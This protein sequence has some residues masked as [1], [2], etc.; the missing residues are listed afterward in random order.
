MAGCFDG[1]ANVLNSP[2]NAFWRIEAEESFDFAGIV[3]P[4]GL[5]FNLFKVDGTKVRVFADLDGASTIPSAGAGEIVLEAAITTGMSASQIATAVAAAITADADLTATASGSIVSVKRV[6]VGKVLPPVDVDFGVKIAICR[7]GQ[8]IALGLLEEVPEV[9]TETNVFNIVSQQTGQAI[10]G[11]L[12]QGAN[13]S[14][15]LTLIETTFE[16]VKQLYGIYGTS[17]FTPSMGT[18][19]AGIG[20]GAIGKSLL[21]EAARL[22]LVPQ[23]VVDANLSYAVNLMLCVPVPT[24]ISFPGDE[25]RR[26]TVEFTGYANQ[27]LN[28]QNINQLLI[29]NA[30]QVGL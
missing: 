27:E 28:N 26:L 3:D 30:S 16:T 2:M 17:S 15:A 13:V 9:T 18:E 12:F 8:N 14:V 7:T 1:V 11:Q 5:E 4:S 24:T 19:V 22:E 23:T 20:S 6:A 25:P 29:G 10:L 21:R